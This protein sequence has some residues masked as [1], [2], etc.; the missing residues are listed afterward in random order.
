MRG[1]TSRL[2]EKIVL[3]GWEGADWSVIRPLLATGELPNL[4]GLIGAGASGNLTAPAPLVSAVL[5]TSLA[6]GKRPQ[7]HRVLG[8]L[9]PCPTSASG[10]R[11]ASSSSR[12][13]RALWNLVTHAGGRS[14]VVGWPATHPAEPI[15]GALVSDRYTEPGGRGMKSW[16]NPEGAVH[17]P[18]LRGA[19]SGLRVHPAELGEPELRPFAP[20]AAALESFTPAALDALAGALASDLSVHALATRLMEAEHWALAAVRYTLID[21]ISRRFLEFHPP[22]MSH[23]SEREAALYGDTVTSAYR[24][25]DRMLGRLLD[26]AGCDATVI[27]VSDHGYHTGRSRPEPGDGSED[28]LLDSWQRPYGIVCMRGP[29]VRRNRE[30]G[31]AHLFDI[32][33][34]ALALFGLPVG[35]DMDGR[36]L[37]QAFAEPVGLWSIRSWEDVPGDFGSHPNGAPA[38]QPT[39]PPDPEAARNGS[40]AQ[41]AQVRNLALAHL[42]AREPDE[43]QPLL[44]ELGAADRPRS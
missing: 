13:A 8:D 22:R 18:R 24:L 31:G 42:E 40:Q 30:L 43:A 17:P 7:K 10:V 25:Q 14:V 15:H 38:P 1:R 20:G 29:R 28:E 32:M 36:A 37:L 34:T 41:R 3:V 12:R 11:P 27:V 23:V 39:A 19:L 26:L 16:P 33:P 21:R 44:E 9:E 35:N 5:W 6:T 4:G 2:A